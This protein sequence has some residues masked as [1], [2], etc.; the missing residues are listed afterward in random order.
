MIAADIATPLRPAS[1]AATAGLSLVLPAY[2]EEAVIGHAIREAAEVLPKI[3][4]RYEILVV[5]DGSRDATCAVAEGEAARHPHV[6]VLRH[7]VNQ[8]YGAALRTGFEAASLPLIAFT[9]ADCQFDLKDLHRMAAL[10]DEFPIVAGYRVHRQDAWNRLF[11]S[12]GYNR[13]IRLLL[14][15][16]VR[17]CD[18]A[19]KIFR[20]DV[21]PHLL[22]EARGYFVNA[23]M[24]ARATRRGVPIAEVGVRHRPR[25][26]GTSKV[27]LWDVPKVL[28]ALIPFWWRHVCN[29]S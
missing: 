27:S 11:Y 28:R 6:R 23:E 20:C 4:I 14:G 1:I 17:D 16:R 5:D 22:P 10:A 7:D 25:R 9:D 19:L 2:N 18:C 29:V 26:G 8:G 3:A 12:W 15:T 13:L 21:L 24:L